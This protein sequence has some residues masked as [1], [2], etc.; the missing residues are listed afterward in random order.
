MPQISTSELSIQFFGQ[1]QITYAQ[2]SISADALQSL[3]AYLILK[4]K[5]PQPRSQVASLFWP[6]SSDKD[7]KAKLRRELYRLRQLLPDDE[8]YLAVTTKTIQWLPQSA[9]WL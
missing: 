5:S 3:L 7:A 4:A 6:D 1:F 2:Q 8:R 9:V